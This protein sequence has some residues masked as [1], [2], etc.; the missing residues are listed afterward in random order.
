MREPAFMNVSLGAPLA[1]KPAAALR[2]PRASA[3]R[4]ERTTPAAR[5]SPATTAGAA[6]AG[7]GAG[8][9]V[10]V[11]TC[12]TTGVALATTIAGVAFTATRSRFVCGVAT[13][14]GVATIFGDGRI[15]GV[16]VG[17]A[18]ARGVGVTDGSGVGVSWRLGL[19]EVGTSNEYGVESGVGATATG[20]GDAADLAFD[21]PKKCASTPPSSSPANTTTRMSGKSGSPPPFDSSLMRRRRGGSRMSRLDQRVANL[22]RN[23]VD[24]V[25]STLD[26][27]RRRFLQQTCIGAR[28]RH[29]RL[30]RPALAARD[31]F[32]RRSGRL[33]G[34]FGGFAALAKSRKDRFDECVNHV[35]RH[36]GE[37]T[38]VVGGEIGLVHLREKLLDCARQHIGRHVP[39]GHWSIHLSLAAGS[40][41]MRQKMTPS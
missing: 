16:V 13:D 2:S 36:R 6:R 14:F 7:F 1:R 4:Y 34:V 20:T 26:E 32:E 18:D 8:A 23:R 3:S 35:G 5:S 37:L 33:C 39:E 9:G 41:S 31:A 28:V 10:G 25:R 40:S 30:G 19:G 11:A 22:R 29:E 12:A 17:D 21:P 27:K 15:A 38:L 24:E